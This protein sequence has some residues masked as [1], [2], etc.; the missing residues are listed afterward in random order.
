MVSIVLGQPTK[1]KLIMIKTLSRGRHF[2]L[3]S[4]LL[5]VCLMVLIVSPSM[6]AQN[7][8]QVSGTVTDANNNP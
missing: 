5:A 1:N 7:K 6:F 3:L 2:S 8:V 4:R